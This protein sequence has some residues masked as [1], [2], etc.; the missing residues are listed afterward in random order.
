MIKTTIIFGIVA[1]ISIVLF[2][3]PRS[4][5]RID[6]Y[7][8]LPA[9]RVS[10]VRGVAPV[11]GVLSLRKREERRRNPAPHIP[12]INLRHESYTPSSRRLRRRVPGLERVPC[13]GNGNCL[14]ASIG[15]SVG[16]DA[17][18]VRKRVAT[19]LWSN[20]REYE[21]FFTS[22]IKNKA[23]A[24]DRHDLMDKTYPKYIERM[25]ESG[26]WGGEMELKAAS[27]VYGRKVEVLD[28][29]FHLISEYEPSSGSGGRGEP[30]R[31]LYNGSSHYDGVKNINIS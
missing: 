12:L 18:L 16:E 29:S 8:P 5:P 19:E 24:R 17:G 23:N 27:S 1:V 21:P 7:S 3:V 2:T 10:P 22:A 15:T 20:R 25:L 28:H 31:V 26:Q 9:K 6:G 14:F 11:G 13:P 4:S 30:I